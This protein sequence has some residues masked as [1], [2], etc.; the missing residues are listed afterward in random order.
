MAGCAG[1]VFARDMDIPV[2]LFPKTKQDPD[3]LSA[4]DLIVALRSV[5]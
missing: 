4:S 3:V 2:L 5:A 1:A